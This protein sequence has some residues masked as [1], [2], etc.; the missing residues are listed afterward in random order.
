MPDLCPGGLWQGHG[1]CSQGLV[2]QRSILGCR[3]ALLLW[4]RGCRIAECVGLWLLGVRGQFNA[5]TQA[6]T[7]MGLFGG[8]TLGLEDVSPDTLL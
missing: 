3:L 5:W 1:L 7:A 2:V 8:W 4:S 6:G